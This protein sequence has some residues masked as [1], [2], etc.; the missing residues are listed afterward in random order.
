M[1]TTAR[2]NYALGRA[3]LAAGDA[4]GAR[5]GAWRRKDYSVITATLRRMR[6]GYA[7]TAAAT[8]MYSMEVGA[9][10]VVFMVL[11]CGVAVGYFLGRVVSA[12]ARWMRA[13]S[14]A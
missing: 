8:A 11:S 1:P 6:K 9:R 4:A 13:T 14:T 3:Y 5:S 12:I 7:F 10:R 2:A